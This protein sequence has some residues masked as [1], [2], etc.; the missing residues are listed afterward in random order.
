MRK[1]PCHKNGAQCRERREKHLPSG[2][3]LK[4]VYLQALKML[5]KCLTSNQPVSG[6]KL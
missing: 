3:F 5:S 4:D 1:Y 6:C 2:L